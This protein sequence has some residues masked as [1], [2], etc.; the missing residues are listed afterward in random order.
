MIVYLIKDGAGNLIPT[1]NNSRDYVRDKIPIGRPI[2]ASLKKARNYKHH[3]KFFALL[4]IVMDNTEAFSSQEE[5]LDWLKLKVGWVR[6]RE[7]STKSG[8]K[9]TVYIPRSISFD[10]MDQDQFEAF[11]DRAVSKILEEILT[12]MS[13]QDL[14]REMG[15]FL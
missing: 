2:R 15:T 9:M 8:E 13:S 3:R 1:D 12:G 10:D 4:R 5:L 14:D 11:Y 7:I 6:T